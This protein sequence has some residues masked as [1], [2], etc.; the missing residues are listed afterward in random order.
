MY[1]TYTTHLAEA[2][3]FRDWDN[4]TQCENPTIIIRMCTTHVKCSNTCIH[5]Y[6]IYVP[7]CNK[8]TSDAAIYGYIYVPS[9]KQ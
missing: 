7:Y 4:P 2:A 1:N 3:C 8:M 9:A 6:I 5:L